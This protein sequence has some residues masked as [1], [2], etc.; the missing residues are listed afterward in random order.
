MRIILLEDIDNIGKKYDVK[1]VKDGY[2]RNFLIPKNLVKVADKETLDWLKSKL[3]IEQIKAEEEL[4]EISKLASKIDGLEVD[5]PVKIGDKGQFFEKINPQKISLVL[6][7]M[8]YDIKKDQIKLKE[9]IKEL[10]EFSATI[11]FAHN[12]ETE[13]KIIVTEKKE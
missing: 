11:K 3:G 12:L 8:G 9:E 2:A 5:I 10:G 7:E 4:K 13:I 1:V 6:Q